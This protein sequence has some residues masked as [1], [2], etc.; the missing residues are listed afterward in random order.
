[1]PNALIAYTTKSDATAE[2]AA[3]I[4]KIM[5]E[6]EIEVDLNNLKTHSNPDLS[7]YDAV[8][9][10]SGIMAGRWYKESLTFLQNNKD[11]LQGKKLGAFVSSGDAS[12]NSDKATTDY[13]DKVASET[14]ISLDLGQAFPGIMDLSKKS[15]HG[16]LAKFVLKIIAKQRAKKSDNEKE[17]DMDGLNDFRNWDEI[18][19]FGHQFAQIVKA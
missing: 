19:E 9:V 8:I 6:Q 12:G 15:R 4:A 10:A 3:E 17:M 14:G 13:I 16:W 7:Q 11:S 5:R 2:T 18:R 1:M